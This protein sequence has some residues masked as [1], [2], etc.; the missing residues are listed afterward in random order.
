MGARQIGHVDLWRRSRVAQRKQ[1]HMWPQGARTASLRW[2]RQTAHSSV[3]SKVDAC[4][5]FFRPP[6]FANAAR[7]LPFAAWAGHG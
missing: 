4:P 1:A 2:R 7:R 5:G 6:S 3:F